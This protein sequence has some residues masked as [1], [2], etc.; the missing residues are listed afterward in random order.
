MSLMLVYGDLET[1]ARLPECF[2]LL[3]NGGSFAMEP[4]PPPLL[5]K[6]RH[7]GVDIPPGLNLR[8]LWLCL[9]GVVW[10]LLALPLSL[11]T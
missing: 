9:V 7:E 3:I 8:T 11:L 5:P 6:G 1:I 2:S 10:T 4:I